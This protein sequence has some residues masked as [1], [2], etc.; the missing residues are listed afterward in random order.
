MNTHQ[1]IFGGQ[2]SE[3]ASEK[4][5]VALEDLSNQEIIF[6]STSTTADVIPISAIQIG[7]NIYGDIKADTILGTALIPNSSTTNGQIVVYEIQASYATATPCSRGMITYINANINGT[8]IIIGQKDFYISEGNYCILR[9]NDGLNVNLSGVSTSNTNE[10]GIDRIIIDYLQFDIIRNQYTFTFSSPTI[11]TD[12]Y[13][14]LP[15]NDAATN[16]DQVTFKVIQ[17]LDGSL[18]QISNITYY[19]NS[20][21]PT[22]QDHGCTLYINTITSDY[23]TLLSDCSFPLTSIQFSTY[24]SCIEAITN[25]NL[26]LIG[27]HRPNSRINLQLKGFSQ[28]GL[29]LSGVYWNYMTGL[30]GFAFS[31]T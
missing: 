14:S 3:P 23:I 29:A 31:N 22:Q 27:T 1:I 28:G 25:N 8:Q 5:F 24:I 7:N 19:N 18:G 16:T 13:S 30:T 20:L 21:K 6:K 10:F 9:S 2:G 4:N 12:S 11:D 26:V 15:Y 17:E